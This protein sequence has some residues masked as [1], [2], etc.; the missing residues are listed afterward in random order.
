[1]TQILCT[2]EF[3]QQITQMIQILCATEF[4][5][6]I[7]RITR[8]LAMRQPNLSNPNR[9]CGMALSTRS[10]KSVKS[11]KSVVEKENK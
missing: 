2:T 6:R 5:Q 10:Q 4:K 9:I 11:V 1:M 3:K 7:I 8:I